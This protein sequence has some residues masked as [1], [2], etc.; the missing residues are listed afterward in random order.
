M[1]KAIFNG[2][3]IKILASAGWN[4]KYGGLE[5]TLYIGDALRTLKGHPVDMLVFEMAD[6]EHYQIRLAGY[7]FNT[8]ALDEQTVAFTTRSLFIETFWFK[9]DDYGDHYVGTFLFPDEY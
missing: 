9:V 5:G 1:D 8:G 3:E 4:D 6:S 7:D 2:K